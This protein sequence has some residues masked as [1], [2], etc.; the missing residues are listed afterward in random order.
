MVV[1]IVAAAESAPGVL[2]AQVEGGEVSKWVNS[3]V[4]RGSIHVCEV[5]IDILNPVK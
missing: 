1:V 2:C 5:G 4:R 3:C